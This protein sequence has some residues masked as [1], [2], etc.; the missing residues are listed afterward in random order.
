VI[1]VA[2]A[3]AAAAPTPVSL[4]G[5]GDLVSAEI[6]PPPPPANSLQAEAER[7]ELEV[8]E[9]TRSSAAIE[10]AK[11]DSETKDATIFEEA[12]GPGFRL[13]RLPQTALLMSMVRGSEKAA[14]DRAKIY[15]RRPR[16]W[17]A[18]PSIGACSRDDD[19]LS[20]YPSGHATMA[21]SMGAV[22][23]RLVPQRAPEI[24]AR[25]ARY[26]ESRLTCEVHYRS[27]VTAGEALGLI[28]AE[29]LMAKRSFV[30]QF[31]LARVELTAVGIIRRGVG[32]H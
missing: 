13:D 5:P 32:E 15:F 7:A 25:A 16:P 4:L 11:R 2:L 8:I 29:R 19:A 14:A 21:F 28:V 1:A 17:I 30:R 3:L 24:M 23:S 12:I 9:R 6:L 22:L 26:G 10:A 20:S 31:R 27:D 18:N